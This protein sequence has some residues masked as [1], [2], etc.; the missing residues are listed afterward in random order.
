MG[1][2]KVADKIGVLWALI[3]KVRKTSAFEGLIQGIS[4]AEICAKAPCW[5][6]P[7]HVQCK[8]LCVH[9]CVCVYVCVCV[10][11]CV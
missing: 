11:V 4:F 10:C 5:C 8:C 1:G 9:L 6:S 7:L 3:K 2:N